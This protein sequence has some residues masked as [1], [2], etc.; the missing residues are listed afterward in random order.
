MDKSSQEP[1][2]HRL[3]VLHIVGKQETCQCIRDIEMCLSK[4]YIEIY[5]MFP[6][7]PGLLVVI[8][9]IVSAAK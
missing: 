3:C 8:C 4:F 9:Q 5:P 2:C 1:L 6:M 7:S